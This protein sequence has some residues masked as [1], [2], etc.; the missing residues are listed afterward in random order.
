M[1]AL[2]AAVTASAP[3]CRPCLP[4]LCSRVHSPPPGF[5]P[6][7]PFTRPPA[8]PARR[9]P[10]RR[11]PAGCWAGLGC[12]RREARRGGGGIVRLYLLLCFLAR[13]GPLNQNQT[14]EEE[15]EG[16]SQAPPAGAARSSRRPPPRAPR[17]C[18]APTPGKGSEEAGAGERGN[19]ITPSAPPQG[20]RQRRSCNPQPRLL[21]CY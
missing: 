20:D 6:P 15:E 11:F 8:G 19:E 12:G 4:L 21:Y 16:C 5:P 18:F 7:A 17:C 3:R 10:E 13:P 2:P 14:R 9:R 1:P